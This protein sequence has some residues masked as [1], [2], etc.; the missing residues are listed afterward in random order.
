[1]VYLVCGKDT[2]RSREKLNQLLDFFNSKIT[3]GAV[4][5]VEADNFSSA[6]FEELVKSRSLFENKHVICCERVLENPEARNF[7]VK[8]FQQISASPNIF[9]FWEEDLE[10]DVMKQFEEASRKIQKFDLLSGE[11]LRKW[12]KEKAGNVSAH[13]VE[14]VIKNCGPDLWRASKQIEMIQAGGKLADER[15]STRE[16][17]LFAA[18]DAVA[19]RNRSKAWILLNEAVM[20]GVAAEEIFFKILWQVKTLMIVKRLDVLKI[21][22]PDKESGLHPFVYKKTLAGAQKFS[23]KELADF[24]FE[25][26]RIYHDSRRGREDIAIGTEKFLLNL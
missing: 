11:K 1:M 2:Y 9:I 14:E 10:D 7:A 12:V 26:L 19:E 4:F 3:S 21:K 23:E 6:Q 22:N 18:S 13:V 15:G 8:N 24:S 25:L 16:F 5:R 20:A 17:N